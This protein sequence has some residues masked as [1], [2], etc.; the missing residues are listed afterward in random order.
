MSQLLSALNQIY[1][2][3]DDFIFIGLTGRTG[4][5]C[6]TV[7]K[8][9]SSDFKEFNESIYTNLKGN[10]FR[11]NK[12]LFKSL[13]KNWVPFITIQVRSIITL[14]F[15]QEKRS[16]LKSFLMCFLAENNLKIDPL[17]LQLAKIRRLSTNANNSEEKYIEFHAKLLPDLC[18]GIRSILGNDKFIELYQLIG[19]NLR[20]SGSTII[21]TFSENNFFTLAVKIEDVC[22]NIFKF[23]RTKQQKTAIVVDAIRN[24]LEAL[25]FQDRYASFYLMAIS[26]VEDERIERLKKTRL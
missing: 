4:S 21:S 2:K 7:A 20:A 24:P 13:E 26:C 5:G 15:S 6:T 12:I 22:K 23:K 14:I 10:E 9:L 19:K 16:R 18:D 1:R 11:K 25:Y 8:L 17:L 3:N